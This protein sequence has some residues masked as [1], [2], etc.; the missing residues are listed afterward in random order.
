MEPPTSRTLPH[1]LDELSQRF[2]DCSAVTGG[3]QEL[4]Y[5]DLRAQSRAFAH[6]LSKL[7]IGRGDHVALL[8]QNRP[9]WLVAFFGIASLGAV[10]VAINTWATAHEL[11]YMLSHSEA[12]ALVTVDRFINNDY[13]ATL[14]TIE[15]RAERLPRLEHV[16]CLADK[17]PNNVIA[18]ADLLAP[19]NEHEG[20][21]SII[22][23]EPNDVAAML[24]TSGS[25]S[26][27][28][29]VPILH[30]GLIENA[31][32][33][34]ERLGIVV[35]DRVWLPSPLFW[36]FGCENALFVSFTHGACL[37]VQ[38]IFDAGEALR[39]LEEE[40]CTVVYVTANMVH[41]VLE[42][43]DFAK[44]DL[45]ALRT[46]ATLGSPAQIEQAARLAP[47]ICH[48]YGLTETY[49]NAI[50]TETTDSLEIRQ[51]SIGM[52]LPG[53]EVVIADPETHEPVA[54]GV[55]GEIKIKGYVTPGY[56]NDPEKN[57]AGF[58]A[59]GFLL[60]GDLAFFGPDGRVYFRGR[61]KE[62]VKTGGIN[63]SPIEVEDV[64]RT[65]PDVQEVF[66]TGVADATHDEIVAAVV[67]AKRDGVSADQLA[68]FCRQT[69]ASYKVPRAFRFVSAEELPV[70]ATGKLQKN[71]LPEF[72]AGPNADVG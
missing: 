65:H 56:H 30:F 7:G 19:R 27:P 55:I 21:H 68:D 51:H 13:L 43:E 23:A 38:D 39:L 35:G 71:R 37:V 44:R 8:M 47:N 28:K 58:D 33:I 34:G 17:L 2:P 49:A 52:P 59:D 72:F 6:G 36:G 32:N 4:T 22:A 46:G 5:G 9:E 12:R 61:L 69:L 62:M 10:A 42:H 63:V 15:P 57:A 45:S 14:A 18:F 54:D 31:W 1:L 50:T 26:T 64:L 48:V 40:S 3:G 25:T 16:V 41:A 53:M 60:T 11:E 24:Y 67:V 20:E 70:T 29:G 66:V